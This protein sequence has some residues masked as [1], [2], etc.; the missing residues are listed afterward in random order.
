[1]C[2]PR[3]FVPRT[4]RVCFAAHLKPNCPLTFV[5]IFALWRPDFALEFN[6]RLASTPLLAARHRGACRP[7]P[8]SRLRACHLL[9]GWGTAR[10]SPTSSEQDQRFW[11]PKLELTAGFWIEVKEKLGWMPP[12]KIAA[13]KKP[14]ATS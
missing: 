5:T 4:R 10:F 6:P 1:M 11:I 7:S 9:T 8:I 13:N 2:P 14:I 3:G 12:R